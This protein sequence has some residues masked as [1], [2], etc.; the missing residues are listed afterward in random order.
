MPSDEFWYGPPRRFLSYA[1]AYRLRLE[2]EEEMQSSI[3]D[4][5]AWLTGLYVNQAVGVVI[6]NAFGGKGKQKA[7]YMQ[8]PISFVARKKRK[9]QKQEN[10][11]DLNKLYIGFRQLTDAMNGG[12][13]KR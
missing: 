12:L 11:D 10:E 4:Y 2:R 7:K 3:I 1:E 6:Q 13:K 9:K 5:Q 8:E